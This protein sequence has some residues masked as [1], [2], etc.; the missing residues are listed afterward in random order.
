MST[1]FF[2][3]TDKQ[4]QE[5]RNL[6]A[7]EGYASKAEFFRFLLKFFKYSRRPEVMHLERS[8]DDLEKTLKELYN[9]KSFD[10]FPSLDE[11]LADV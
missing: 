5:I 1:V 6:M 7:E 2:K 4:D 3:I 8:I 10:N 11:Q 9:K